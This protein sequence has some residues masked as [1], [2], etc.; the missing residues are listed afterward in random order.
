[1]AG[2]DQHQSAGKAKAAEVAVSIA[3]LP[4]LDAGTELFG[5]RGVGLT[6]PADGE[7]RMARRGA[8]LWVFVLQPGDDRRVDDF[9]NSSPPSSP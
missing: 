1:M 4:S 5:R 9:T 2:G 6:A 8:G 3:K 7:A